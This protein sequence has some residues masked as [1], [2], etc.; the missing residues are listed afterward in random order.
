MT[1]PDQCPQQLSAW[2]SVGVAAFVATIAGLQWLTARRQYKAAHNRAVFDLFEKRYAVYEDPRKML[3]AIGDYDVIPEDAFIRATDA[4]RRGTFLFGVELRRELQDLLKCLL[5]LNE[6]QEAGGL[7]G[8]LEQKLKD[9]IAQ[10]LKK[11]RGLFAPYIRF[12]QRI[13]P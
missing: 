1:T 4:A 3:N 5:D 2:I 13:I 11:A 12:D 10:F 9:Q 8:H 7:T 6:L